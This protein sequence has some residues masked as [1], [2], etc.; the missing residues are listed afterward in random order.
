MANVSLARTANIFR[1]QKV[2]FSAKLGKKNKLNE[3]GTKLKIQRN[4]ELHNGYEYYAIR[5][6]KQQEQQDVGR[7]GQRNVSHNTI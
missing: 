2:S 6:N 7:S 5:N 4:Y 1:A 3:N